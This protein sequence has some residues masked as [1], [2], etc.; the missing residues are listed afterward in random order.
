MPPNREVKFGID[1][2]LEISL[3]FTPSYRMAPID[4]VEQGMAGRA[5]RASL[6]RTLGFIH[7]LNTGYSQEHLSDASNR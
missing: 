7:V 4:L 5:S 2:L 3:I 6:T 1:L